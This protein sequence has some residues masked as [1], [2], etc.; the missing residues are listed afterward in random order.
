MRKVFLLVLMLAVVVGTQYMIARERADVVV[1]HE[2]LAGNPVDRYAAVGTPQG[3]VLVAHG[4]SA[5]KEFMQPWGYALARQGFEV[6]LF[7]QPGH[8]AQQGVL[9]AWRTLADNPLGNNL[10]AMVAELVQTGRATP[11]RIALVGHSMGG[12]TVVAAGLMEP[13]VAATVAVSAAYSDPLPADRPVNLLSI[14]AERDPAMIRSA[15]EALAPQSASRK[16]LDVAA[17]NHI[18]ILYDREVIDQAAGWIHQALGTKQ[19]GPVGAVAPWSWILAALAAGVGAVLVVARLLAPPEVRSGGRAAALGFFT[20]LAALAVAALS[21]VLGTVYLRTPWLGLAVLDYLLPY[22]ALAAVVLLLLRLLWPR[23]F[24]FT[25]TQGAD[26]VPTAVM[27][28]LGVAL[29]YLGAVVPVVHMNLAYHML[30]WQ[31]LVPFLVFALVL[32]LYF[33]QEEG[34]KRAVVY[35]WGSLA[36]LALGIVAK[37]VIVGTWLGATALPNP[38]FFITLTIPVTVAML[39]LLEVLAALLGRMRYSSASTAT[40]NAVVLAWAVAVTFPLQ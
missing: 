27:R 25:L 7:D 14:V 31:R 19:P 29:A 11:G 32:W 35:Q 8:G 40:L 26:T 6:Y 18:T 4:F 2:E 23:D 5:S 13:A 1:S 15:A 16:V 3:T 22:F 9:P 24:A 34:L 37:L 36:G 20:G 10:R 28:G 12:A 38:P 39:L 30:G 33:V 17:R 21:A